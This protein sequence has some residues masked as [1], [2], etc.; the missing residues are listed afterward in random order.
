MLASF[1]F[2]ALAGFFTRRAEPWIR[3]VLE[4]LAMRDARLGDAESRV[5]SL[6]VML[7]LAAAATALI[8]ADSS[9][10]LTV[11]GGLL[12]Y[13]G[14]DLYVFLRDPEA[15]T[16]EEE[17]DGVSPMPEPPLAAWCRSVAD[18]IARKLNYKESD[19]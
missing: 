17:A 16:D 13:F 11:S 9:A 1:L 19:T 7:L 2:G 8:G 15:E 4:R 5:V 18:A 14:G 12:G 10:Y 6:A 3:F